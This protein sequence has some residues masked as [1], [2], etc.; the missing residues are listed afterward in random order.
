MGIHSFSTVMDYTIDKK[1]GD[2]TFAVVFGKRA[3]SVFALV[4][5]IST[6]MFSKIG[7]ASINYYVAFCSLLFLIAL[8][9]PSERLAFLLFKL[10]FIG[11]VVTAVIFLVS[12]L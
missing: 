9:F 5:F 7:R 8:I 3:A 2:K 10:I 6:L 11:F 12:Y 1:V 4:L